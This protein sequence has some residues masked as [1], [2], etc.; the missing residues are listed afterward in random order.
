[1]AEVKVTREV[2]EAIEH[3]KRS[4]TLDAFISFAE[5]GPVSHPK[6]RMLSGEFGKDELLQV[7]FYGYEVEKTP[8]ELMLAEFKAVNGACT[9]RTEFGRAAIERRKGMLVTLETLGIKIGGI[10][11]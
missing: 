3:V 6:A 7:L 1:M 8:E 10:N 11:A 5:G 4:Y 9:P 2:A